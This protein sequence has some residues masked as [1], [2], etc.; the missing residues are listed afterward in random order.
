LYDLLGKGLSVKIVN[1]SKLQN[2]QSKWY[3]TAPTYYLGDSF[4]PLLDC[5]VESLLYEE[6]PPLQPI[7]WFGA[8]PTT[9]FGLELGHP[10]NII[11]ELDDMFNERSDYSSIFSSASLKDVQR[12]EVYN[13]DS[14]ISKGVLLEYSSGR[15]EVVGQRPL[16]HPKISVT[17]TQL[18]TRL[19]YLETPIGR[20]SGRSQ[21]QVTFAEREYEILPAPGWKSHGMDG[22][23][24]WS[25][26]YSNDKIRFED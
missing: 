26:T 17:T 2:S 9:E 4:Q 22:V 18:P 20:G 6:P 16:G 24:L 12:V 23:L 3:S 21:V 1:I 14:G 10:S 13:E 19:F 11:N 8:T 15:Q 5:D 25:F 7:T